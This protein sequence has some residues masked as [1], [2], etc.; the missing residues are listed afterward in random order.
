MPRIFNATSEISDSGRVVI[1]PQSSDCVEVFY[2]PSKERL[3]QSTLKCDSVK[4]SRVKL[5][6]IDRTNQSLTVFP[7]NTFPQSYDPD[8]FLKPK[9]C[10]IEAI[11]IAE[12]E[13]FD[14][15]I[16]PIIFTD[17]SDSDTA[18]SEFDLSDGEKVMLVLEDLPSCFVKDYEYGLGLTKSHRFIVHAVENLSDCTKIVISKRYQTGIDAN[19][20]TFYIA[21]D[22]FTEVRKSID[23]T[24]RHS[25]TAARS[26][27]H[28][29]THNCFAEKTNQ[30]LVPVRTGR[31]TLRRIMTEAAIHGEDLLSEDEQDGVL[32]VLARNT[33]SI[34]M[35]KPKK[36]AILK[37]DI[38]VVTLETLIERYREMIQ[39]RIPERKWQEFLD[40]N[41]FI[42]SL[43]FGHPIVRV[44]GQASVGGHRISGAGGTIAD[45]VVRNSLTNNSAI[46]EI[47]TPSSGLLKNSVYRGGIYP[48]SGELVGA[49]NQALKQRYSFEQ[50][51]AQ[52]KQNSRIYDLESYAVRCCLII[53]TMPGDEDK[54]QSFE[55]F[56]GNSKNVDIVTFD[57]LLRKLTDLRDLL[58]TSECDATTKLQAS[59]LPF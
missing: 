18:N 31:S 35:D 24:I 42:L 25:Q 19:N 8:A 41:S 54:K 39:A 53:G 36:L 34:A 10:K 26:V 55:L 56:R 20:K 48:P 7:V 46:V 6:N 32:N 37:K 1:E 30:P 3:Q 50:E 57:E 27:N 4:E 15:D 9:Y 23:K 44:G 51:I 12:L 16:G 59:E 14:S 49:V 29:A 40:A 13:Y 5:L 21:T 38:E 47:K 58:T 45:F 28:A 11:T 43:A 33:K 22:D 2:T 52:I 17:K